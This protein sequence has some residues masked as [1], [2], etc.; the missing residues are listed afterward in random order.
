[1]WT[2]DCGEY[3]IHMLAYYTMPYLYADSEADEAISNLYLVRVGDS[4]NYEWII[5]DTQFTLNEFK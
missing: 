4:N 2:D 1:M 5:F 3:A